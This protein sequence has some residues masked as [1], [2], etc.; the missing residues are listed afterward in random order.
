MPDD[1]FSV[2]FHLRLAL[3]L[4][5][6]PACAACTRAG[7]PAAQAQQDPH[8][9]HALCCPRGP[10]HTGRH[11]RVKHAWARV[12]EDALG[13]PPL[14][15]QVIPEWG[16]ADG[17]EARLDLSFA[18]PGG[19]TR[20]ADVTVGHP[21]GM[22]FCGEGRIRARRRPRAGAGA[23][24]ADPLPAPRVGPARPGERRPDGAGRASAH[25]DAPRAAA[26]GREGRG[27]APCIQTR[28]HGFAAGAGPN[29]PARLT[30]G[31]A[32][33]A[34]LRERGLAGRAAHWMGRHRAGS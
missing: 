25:A 12:L 6:P 7:V 10:G 28:R 4:Q 34:R 21:N 30:S 14:V 9:V 5:M 19:R 22:G 33:L 16:A 29:G 3:P 17:R 18:L 27:D 13:A 31:R 1:E 24:E 15:E 11:E 26:A 32:G 2:A 8:G 20:H 23:P